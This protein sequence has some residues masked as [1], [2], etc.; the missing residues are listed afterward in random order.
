[1]VRRT[2]TK[3]NQTERRKEGSGGGGRG[4]ALAFATWNVRSLVEDSGDERICRKRQNNNLSIDRKLDFL[5]AE[6]RRYGIAI[7]AIQETKWFESDVWR[8]D[9]YTFLHS[10]RRLPNGDGPAR[11]N[12]GVGI[13]LNPGMTEAWRRAGEQ[14]TAVSSRL[15]VARLKLAEAGELRVHGEWQRRNDLYVTVVSA[16]APTSKATAPV[17]DHFFTDLQRV[18]DGVPAS[19]VLL[20]L[21]DFNARVG[22]SNDA[23][24]EW[25]AVLGRYGHGARNDAGERLLM[26]CAT[27]GLSVMNTHFQKPASRRGTWMHPATKQTHLID[28]IIMRQPHRRFCLDVSVMRGANCWTDHHMVRSRILLDR[29]LCRRP[30]PV[31]KPAPVAVGKLGDPAVRKSFAEQISD[32]LP[33]TADADTAADQ[34]QAVKDIMCSTAEDVLGPRQRRQPDW[35]KASETV[36]L[37][38]IDIKNSAGDVMLQKN[39][40]SS[41]KNFRQTQREVEKAVRSAKETWIEDIASQAEN[42]ANNCSVRWAAVRKLQTLHQGRRPMQPSAVYLEDGTL[43]DGPEAVS[44]RWLQHFQGVLNVE[45]EFDA[46]VVEMMADRPVIPE[47]DQPPT[48]AELEAALRTMKAGKAGGQSGI[49]PDMVLH[50]GKDLHSRILTIMRKSWLEGTV[51]DDWR[52]AVV[53]PIPK[54]GDLHHCDNWRGI[55]LLD[56]VGKLLARILQDRLK[57]IAENVLPDSQ[58]GFRK[59]RGCVDMVYVARQL[60]EKTLEHDSDAYVLFVDLRKAYDSI[61]RAALWQVLQKLGVPPAMLRII[62]SLHNGM[63]ASVRV[64][65]K[66]TDPIT[67]RNGLR[68]GCTLAPMLFNLYFSAVVASWRSS[69]PDAG[70]SFHYK[71]GDRTVKGKLLSSKVTESQFADDAALYATSRPAFEAMTSSFITCASSWG[72]TVSVRKTK[73]MAVGESADRRDVV[74]GADTIEVVDQFTYLGSVLSSDGLACA[75][76]RSRLAKA[77]AVFGA[78]KA[79]VFDN[80]T[81][82]L[83]SKRRVYEAVVL[84]TLLYG[85]ETWTT[86]AGHLQKLNT[87]HHQCVRSIVGIGRRQQWDDRIS[88]ATLAA[89]FGVDP[90]ITRI[91][92]RH[93]LRW[94]GHVGR[95]DDSRAPKQLLFGEL[96]APVLVTARRRDGEMWC[97]L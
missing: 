63:T 58:C 74:V 21:G 15:V 89:T 29:P 48:V 71:V 60:M 11:R 76:V 88:T 82:S 17:K 85:A 28:F 83:R 54:K 32:K 47:L 97:R 95:M 37:P 68:Q 77:S 64:D 92:R 4:A 16:Y 26:W 24:D 81:L 20:L 52:D 61:P 7:A 78:L 31:P 43:S 19:D 2:T 49:L 84:T 86:K 87:F 41:R 72:L 45:S 34:W 75:D 14:W 93:R 12:E 90:D 35:F 66:L 40:A 94:L 9:G 70:I 44:G 38:L 62:Q 39:T 30:R 73:G 1:M 55:S 18:V 53:V 91:I 6:L 79:P 25:R 22:S 13:M 27:N 36:L 3:S 46:A 33:D 69:C 80:Q 96:L 42:A 67:V 65:G 56:V 57:A 50:G 10:G 59:G 5:V 23:G 8:A 51:V